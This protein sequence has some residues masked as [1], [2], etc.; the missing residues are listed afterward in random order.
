MNLDKYQQMVVDCN[1]NAVVSAGAGSGKTTVLAARFLRLIKEGRADVSEI[2][3][4]TFTRKAAAEMYERIYKQLLKEQ[5]NPECAEA[6]K[7]FD[8]SSIST[9]DSFCSTIA[10]GCCSDFGIPSNFSTDEVAVKALAEE[11]S[12]DFI[13]ANAENPFMKDFIFM[14]GFEKV[15]NNFFVEISGNYLSI[16][17]PKDFTQMY[18]FQMESASK[19]LLKTAKELEF[20][21]NQICDIDSKLKAV[22]EASSKLKD[23]LDFGLEVE[24]AV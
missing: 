15:W 16:G 14:N 17:E 13:L 1:T 5:N 24:D 20:L 9:L 4:L 19:E 6:I 18:N 7:K 10:R 3:T 12:L 23:F 11:T 21:S 8:R 22:I 2:L